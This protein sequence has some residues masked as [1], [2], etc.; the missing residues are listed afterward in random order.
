M[1]LCGVVFCRDFSISHINDPSSSNTTTLYPVEGYMVLSGNFFSSP[2]PVEV[3]QLPSLA[4]FYVEDSDIT[5]D[6]SFVV[7]M[8]TAGR[9]TMKRNRG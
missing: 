8:R 6:L 1:V 5:G 2:I 9:C 7:P 3:G 4:N